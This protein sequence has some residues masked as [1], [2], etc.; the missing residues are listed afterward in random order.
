MKLAWLFRV[1]AEPPRIERALR[2]VI[3]LDPG[4]A[5]AHFDLG[6]ELTRQGRRAEAADAFK[7]AVR[8]TPSLAQFVPVSP[9][10]TGEIVGA[11][12]QGG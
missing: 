2:R 5:A 12:A 10:R 8:L 6:K 3:A 1:L 9:L 11:H 7:E 4:H